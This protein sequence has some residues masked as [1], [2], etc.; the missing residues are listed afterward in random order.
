M[1]DFEL[2]DTEH[3]LAETARRVFAR[4][5]EPVLAAHPPDRALPKAVMCYR[6]LALLDR[7][8]WCHRE[9][10]AAKAFATEAAVR[11]TNLAVQLR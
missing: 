5:V 10:S 1:M 4:D 9:S 3:M 2:S 6:A 11:V 8:V 7:G